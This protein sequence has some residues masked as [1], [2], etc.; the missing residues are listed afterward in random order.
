MEDKIKKTI[1][2]VLVL[3][4]FIFTGNIRVNVQSEDSITRLNKINNDEVEV[5]NYVNNKQMKS[6]KNETSVDSITIV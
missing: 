5:I 2:I 4:A 6:N 3:I 1:T